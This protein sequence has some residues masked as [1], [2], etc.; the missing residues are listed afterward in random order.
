MTDYRMTSEQTARVAGPRLNPSGIKPTEPS[1]TEFEV[2]GLKSEYNFADG[3]AYHE[4]PQ[5]LRP[6][7]ANLSD[8]WAYAS[9]KSIPEMEEEFKSILAAC[10]KSPVLAEH[11]HYSISPTASNSIDIVGAWMHSNGYRVGLLEPAFDNLYLMLKRRGVSIESIQEESLVDLDSLSLTIDRNNLQC[12]FIITPN[13]PTGFELNKLQ[14]SAL[15][16]LCVKKG[17]KLVVDKTFRFYSRTPYDEYEIVDSSGVDFVI[18]ED[19]GKTWPTQDLKVSLIA[20]S[21]GL[22]R[23]L[24][25]LYEEIFLCSSNFALALLGQLIERTRIVGIEKVIWEEVDRRKKLVSSVLEGTALVPMS[26]EQNCL[27]FSWIDCSATRMT[28]IDV[29]VKLREFNISLLPGRYFFWNSPGSHT[30]HVRLSLMRP[31]RVFEGIYAMR[32]IVQRIPRMK[33]LK[34]NKG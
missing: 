31:K 12:L 1:L 2:Q 25:I 22:A 21:E 9:S 18:I 7:I 19:T 11:R 17:V 16:H 29:L 26:G 33:V 32:N 13:N 27:P 28:D 14:F 23:E 30:T 6:V 5:A 10:I 8:T 15:C 4:I 24:R 34:N 20:Y 3:H